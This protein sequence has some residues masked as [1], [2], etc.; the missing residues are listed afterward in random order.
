MHAGEAGGGPLDCTL[1]T[2]GEGGG[3]SLDWQLV[4]RAANMLGGLR[5]QPRAAPLCQLDW[6]LH[7]GDD[8]MVED[9]NG[10]LDKIFRFEFPILLISSGLRIQSI[11]GRIR[12]LQIRSLKWDPDPGSYWHL[13]NQFK[14]LNFFHIKHI[15]F[16]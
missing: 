15:P 5:L 7:I 13:K 4:S 14:H 16:F 11:F 3:E 2:Q 10:L 8:G 12:I 1:T 6:E 9:V